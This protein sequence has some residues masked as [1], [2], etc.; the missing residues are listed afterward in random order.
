MTEV[1]APGVD[2]GADEQSTGVS[3]FGI[4]ARGTEDGDDDAEQVEPN[5]D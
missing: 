5:D 1:H 3:V 2:V 4:G